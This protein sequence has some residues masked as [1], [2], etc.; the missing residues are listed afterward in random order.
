MIEVFFNNI[1]NAVQKYIDNATL[2]VKIAV[3]WFTNEDL[4]RS[5]VNALNRGVSV[6]VVILDDMINRNELA[7]DFSQFKQAGGKLYFSDKRKMHNKFCVIDDKVLLTGSYNWTYYAENLNWENI[8]II[9]DVEVVLK[10]IKEFEKICQSMKTIDTYTPLKFNELDGRFLYDNYTYLCND[11]SLKSKD[12]MERIERI[13][14]EEHRSVEIAELAKTQEYDKTGRIPILRKENNPQIPQRRIINIHIDSVPSNMSSANR[15]YIHA[16]LISNDLWAKE[17]SVF[18]IDEE[19]VEKMKQY[20]HKRDGGIV[21]DTIPLPSVPAD[22]Y[23]PGIKYR[24]RLATCYFKD[25]KEHQQ[26]DS[27]G[28]LLPYQ[29]KSFNLYT[30]IGDDLRKYIGFDSLTEQFQLIVSSLFKPNRIEDIDPSRSFL[31]DNNGVFNGSVDDS[32][33]VHKFIKEYNAKYPQYSIEN[34]IT[35]Y[36]DNPKGF[37]IKWLNGSVSA[38]LYG[39]Y[40]NHRNIEHDD[41]KMSRDTKEGEWFVIKYCYNNPSISSME[42][43]ALLEYVITTIKDGSAL[44]ILTLWWQ[45]DGNCGYKSTLM[46]LGFKPEPSTYIPSN[47]KYQRKIMQYRLTFETIKNGP[48]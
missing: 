47:T 8:V 24:F 48:V 22:L 10:F 12:A 2:N 26:Y 6:T 21:D 15:K 45:E 4:F 16:K 28:H 38:L 33:F 37:Y 3:A 5:V 30:R 32:F 44:G 35:D 18:I 41:L 36:N 20:F 23:T 9:D 13:N 43:R 11:L 34:V 31:T 7:L 42:W 25:N 17:I 29:Y 40:I 14:R 19:Y 46:S 27:N 39:G 1:A